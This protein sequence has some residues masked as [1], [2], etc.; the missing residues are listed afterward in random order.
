MLPNLITKTITL[1]D[2]REIT[3]ETGALAKQADGSVVV[4]MGKAMLLATV[5][6]KKEAGEGVDF[7]PMSV[8][9]QEKFASSGKI[10]GGFLKRE[11]RLSDYEIL[12]SR[13]VDRAIR[14]IFPDDYHADTQIA[15][16]L[17]SGD[18]DVLPDALAGLAASAA[19]A[20]SDIPFNGPISEVRVAKIDGKLKIN[21]SP[22]ELEKASLEFIVAGSLEFILM[23]EGEANEIQEEEMLEAMQYAHEEIKRHCQAQIELTKLVGK[24]VKREYNHEKSDPALFDKM[25]ADVYD[26][27]YASVSKLIANKSE[28]SS[29]IKEIKEE[30]VASLGEEH[31]FEASL[32][33]PYFSK[34]HKEAARNLTLDEKK[35]LDGR[36]LDE[37]RPIWSVVDYLPSA[38]GSAVFTRGETQSLTTCTLGTKMDEMMVDGATISGYNKFYLHYNFPGFS[39]GEVKINRGPG[40][41]EVGHGNLAMRALKKVLPPADQNPY[42]I[43]IVSDI[44]E[45]NGSSSMATVCAGSLALMDA[46][47]PIKSA[48]TGIAMGM[49]S[50]AKTGKYSILSDI[51]GDEDHLGDMDF[52]VTGTAKG[53][54]ACQMDLKVEGLDY[55]VLKEALLQA[56]DGRLHIL[57]EITKTLAAPKSELKPHTPRSFIMMIPKELIGAVIGPG[58]K[59]IQEIQKDTGATIVIE[60]IDNQGKINIFSAN[61]D[62]LNA[63]LSRIKSIV[64][65]P[66]IGETYTGK[67]K[68]I[69]PFG[70]FVEFMPGK[71]GLLHI[72]EIKHER[73]ETMDGVLEPGEEIQVKL[74]DVDKKTGKFKLSR[75]ALLP[76]PEKPTPSA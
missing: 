27:L 42:T 75:K 7:L 64:A 5:M 59:V 60:E 73:V 47:I 72:S 29:L 50:D 52:K 25:R 24:E 23:V 22:T 43:R 28:R 51:L 53:I 49:I 74:I 41:R 3:I 44:L 38:H 34:I 63:A 45:S 48:V 6:S 16:T 8:D 67:V 71:D 36:K 17:I 9:Y 20:V 4:K 18:E 55:S 13:I 19:L 76:K 65:Q 11:G 68:N 58:G 14:P 56:K 61:Q 1:E 57:D 40:R 33:G 69:Q 39:T 70:A 66:E 31:E 12:I 46:G 2:G 15:I 54:T 30:F 32:I 35:R 10:P 62:K 26:K 21:P 37:V